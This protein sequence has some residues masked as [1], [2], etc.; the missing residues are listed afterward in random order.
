M[1]K[2][3]NQ[4]KYLVDDTEVVEMLQIIMLFE[5]GNKGKQI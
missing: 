5:K 3:A 1:N 2:A 4:L